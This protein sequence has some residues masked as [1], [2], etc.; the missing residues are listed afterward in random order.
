MSFPSSL[1]SYTPFMTP[2]TLQAL[3][4]TSRHA[5][6]EADITAIATKVGINSSADTSSLDYMLAA[7]GTRINNIKSGAEALTAPTISS[8]ANATHNHQNATG[9]GVLAAPGIT[10]FANALHDHTNSAGGGVLATAAHADASITTRK[11]KPTII[12]FASNGSGETSTTNTTLTDITDS[13]YDYTSGS[14]AETLEIWATVM[15]WK[16]TANAGEASLNID[17][18]DQ[19]QFFYTEPADTWKTMTRMF[20]VNVAANATIR[21][22]IRIRSQ[23]AGGTLH[24]YVGPAYGIQYRIWAISQ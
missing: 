6:M 7:L 8:F 21:F 5:Q 23:S 9:G 13:I 11:L 14:T 12:N 15:M 10:S 18:V 19:P 22:K 4:H 17:G 3:Q 2:I 24:I 20:T 16:D 1:P